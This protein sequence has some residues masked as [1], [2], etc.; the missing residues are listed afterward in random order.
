[1]KKMLQLGFIVILFFPTKSYYLFFIAFIF[2]L[3]LV[4]VSN[5]SK[6]KCSINPFIILFFIYMFL[7]SYFRLL[8]FELLNLRDF[9]EIS[10]FIPILLILSCKKIF[11]LFD[12]EFLLKILRIYIIID[13]IISYLQFY[14][15]NLGFLKLIDT[16]YASSH[17]LET[18]LKIANRSLGLSSNPG[19]H[20]LTI[21]V[22][23]GILIF[24][25]LNKKIKPL[26]CIIKDILIIY[27]GYFSILFSQSQT[28]FVGI[29]LLNFLIIFFLI[30]K[31]LKQVNLKG[32]ILYVLS[33]ALS[34]NFFIAYIKNLRYLISLFEVGLHRSSYLERTDKWE[35]LIRKVMNA[36]LGIFIGW[37]KSFFGIFSSSMDNEHLYI[38]LCYGPIIY[39]LLFIGLVFFIY[40]TML[41]PSFYKEL[42]IFL[43][44][45]GIPLAWPNAYF[46]TPKIYFLLSLIFV[47]MKNQNY[48][49][50]QQGVKYA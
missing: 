24:N 16:L 42:F 50:F 46:L 18:S 2:V 17:H 25:L 13:F 8:W 7:G 35:F 34:I 1:M 10:R 14:H 15:I 12:F 11:T 44:L 4:I 47:K 48:L 39:L 38:F 32:L 26:K 31:G 6:I 40:K 23:I 22:M 28:A 45:L 30:L 41:R 37:G 29:F 43:I 9:I 36:P 49:K 21:L 20:G 5:Y 33:L 27:L 3:I 19:E